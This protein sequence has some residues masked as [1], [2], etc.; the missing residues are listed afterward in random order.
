MGY[1]DGRMMSHY[2]Q[3]PIPTLD[4]KLAVATHHLLD[5]PKGNSMGDQISH[6]MLDRSDKSRG[7]VNQT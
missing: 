3:S 7:S 2:E 6:I 1:S 5:Q 4:D